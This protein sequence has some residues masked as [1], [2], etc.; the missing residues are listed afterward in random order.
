MYKDINILNIVPGKYK[1]NEFGDIYS[2]YKNKRLHPYLDKDGYMRVNLC[3]NEYEGSKN[4]NHKRKQFLVHTLVMLI[5]NGVAPQHMKD[6]TVDHIDHN[7]INNYNSNLRWLE[8]SE[9]TKC[10]LVTPIGERNGSAKLTEKQVIEICELLCTGQASLSDIA[11]IY[12]T[13]KSTISNIRRKVKW[14][15]ISTLYDFAPPCSSS[16]C[17]Q[18]YV[19]NGNNI[20]KTY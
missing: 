16:H 20:I 6:P 14:R 12:H 9:N 4:L 7:K 5:F 17:R 18:R 1:I 2:T 15:H 13:D 11:A 3:T 8:R 10:R 19:N